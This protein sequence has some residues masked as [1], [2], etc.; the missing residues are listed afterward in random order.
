MKLNL[1]S[2]INC[3]TNKNLEIIHPLTS[4]NIPGTLNPTAGDNLKQCY[5]QPGFP[6]LN[7]A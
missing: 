7:A 1:I 3:I 6:T 4:D 2:M 5:F